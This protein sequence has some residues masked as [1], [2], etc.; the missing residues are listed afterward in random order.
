MRTVLDPRDEPL[1]RLPASI[2]RPAR[3]T[4]ST[5]VPG[6]TASIPCAHAERTSIAEGTTAMGR[7]RMHD[8]GRVARRRQRPPRPGGVGSLWWAKAALAPGATFGLNRGMAKASR[9][10]PRART[11]QTSEVGDRRAQK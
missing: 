8:I 10:R 1:A 4:P 3:I 2:T 6:E 5:M 7:T 11:R 9:T